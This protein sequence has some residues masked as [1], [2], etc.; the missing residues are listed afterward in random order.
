[1]WLVSATLILEV[2]G[3]NTEVVYLCAR[4]NEKTGRQIPT[5]TS[6]SLMH[7]LALVQVASLTSSVQFLGLCP[8]KARLMQLFSFYYFLN[9]FLGKPISL[10][11]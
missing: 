8:F 7:I 2:V 6:F 3:E 4:V 1:M 10:R 9:L 5:S 11:H